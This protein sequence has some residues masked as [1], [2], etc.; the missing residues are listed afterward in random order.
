MFRG[1]PTAQ[2]TKPTTLYGAVFPKGFNRI[3]VELLMFRDAR[4]VEKGGL[5]KA[6]HFWRV[7][8]IL[9]G[10]NNP[11]QKVFV[12]TPWAERMIENACQHKYLAVAG[13]S[14]SGKSDCYAI[15]AIVN[16]LADPEHTQVLVTSTSLK[17]SRKRIWGKIKEYWQSLGNGFPGKLVDSHGL[18]RHPTLGETCGITLLAGDPKREKEAVG[19]MIGIKA[20]RLLF[21]ADELTELSH[22]IL[23]ACLSNLG[24]NKKYFQFTGLA[25]PNSYFD[26]FGELAQP[27]EGWDSIHADKE[28]WATRYGWC[29]RLDGEK[30]PNILAGEVLYPFLPTQ[31]TIDELKQTRGENSSEYWRMIR[32]YWSPSGNEESIYSEADIMKF[33]AG[34]KCE[35]ISPPEKI[36]SLDPGFTAGGNR[37]IYW[38]GSVGTSREGRRVIQFEKKIELKDDVTNKSEPRNFQIARQFVEQCKRDGV[39][40]KRVALDTTGG[41]IGFADIV[42]HI[43]GNNE[44]L[45]VCFGGNASNKPMSLSNR[46]PANE[47]CANRVTEIWLAC[48][49]LMRNE[50]IRGVTPDLAKEMTSRRYDKSIKQDGN[51]KVKVESKRDMKG[52]VGESC[53]LADSAF[54]L[55]DLCRQRLG[56][57]AQ[58]PTKNSH[59]D[60]VVTTADNPWRKRFSKFNALRSRNNLRLTC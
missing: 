24:L 32:G 2:F 44:F 4:S 29:L 46:K 20:D 27:K 34:K 16:Y 51:H 41:G 19:K 18:I 6:E 14:N 57:S 47:V 38:L 45:R 49:E 35:W 59:G 42:E 5:G 52:R 9:W 30:S 40:P 21:V 53:D 56:F 15:W 23:A 48:K 31:A 25:N 50:Q 28:E 3:M 7:V 33:G 58:K 60:L 1:D 54:V 37:S 39:S 55:V 17:E 26:P 43:W 36:S 10:P 13:A 22:A 12:R 8:E 11:G